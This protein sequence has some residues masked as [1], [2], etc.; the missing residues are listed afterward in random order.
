MEPARNSGSQEVGNFSRH[1]QGTETAT[2]Q[3]NASESIKVGLI[4]TSWILLL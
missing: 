3:I 2:A 4:L 1:I